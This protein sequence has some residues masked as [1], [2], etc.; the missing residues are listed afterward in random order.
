[1]EP[2]VQAIEEARRRQHIYITAEIPRVRDPAK[3]WTMSGVSK[4]LVGNESQF[5]YVAP[6]ESD[7]MTK[8]DSWNRN[9]VEWEL[10]EKDSPEGPDNIRVTEMTARAPLRFNADEW[11][12]L[13]FADDD[14]GNDLQPGPRHHARQ[15]GEA[16]Y[17]QFEQPA[18]GV[19]FHTGYLAPKPSEI[20][21]AISLVGN[22][23]RLPAYLVRECFSKLPP[24]DLSVRKGTPPVA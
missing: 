6:E 16:A 10:E 3:P 17:P 20:I 8:F 2:L 14:S 4:P 11:P 19:S 12:I 5:T 24:E 13:S 23:C 7:L 21:S 15:Q 1:M 18:G 22:E 9:L